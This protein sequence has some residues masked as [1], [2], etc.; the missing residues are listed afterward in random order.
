MS[1]ETVCKLQ[2]ML[3]NQADAEISKDEIA[4][5]SGLMDALRKVKINDD[6]LNITIRGTNNDGTSFNE[7][8]LVHV[9]SLVCSIVR[10]GLE[11]QRKT[12]RERAVI[13]FVAKVDAAAE[14]VDAVAE[15]VECLRSEFNR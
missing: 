4:A 5:C 10:A 3:E 12:R 8:K 6:E 7:Q 1:A 2:K 14:K 9:Y 15:E 11:K 13:E